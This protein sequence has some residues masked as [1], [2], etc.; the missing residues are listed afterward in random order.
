VSS[1]DFVHCPRCAGSLEWRTFESGAARHPVCVSCGFV[2]WQNRLSSVEALIVRG[3]A[4]K[5][6]VLL[7][8]RRDTGL[9]DLPGGFLN[10][11]DTIAG[12]L[13]RN[14][15]SEVGVEIELLEI[16]G[17]YEDE[18]EGTSIVSIVYTCSVMSG[19]PRAAGPID[20]VE[21]FPIFDVPELAFAYARLAVADLQASERQ[22]PGRS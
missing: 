1:A 22:A 6:E 9:W 8:R 3:S 17:A 15:R 21:W 5:L 4:A 20:T 7:G 19:E 2:L 14:C 11:S 18:F 16:V 12:A 10:A 13:A